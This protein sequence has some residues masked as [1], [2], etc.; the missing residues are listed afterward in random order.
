MPPLLFSLNPS[1]RGALS[2]LKQTR[3]TVSAEITT[4][5]NEFG[6]ELFPDFDSSRVIAATDLPAP[7]PQPQLARRR[8]SNSTD[9]DG[10]VSPIGS[11]GV[12]F[13]PLDL[14][15]GEKFETLADI[16]LFASRP[17]TRPPSRTG[18]RS[19]STSVKDGVSIDRLKGFT[20]AGGDNATPE[21]IEAVPDFEELTKH[22][23]GGMTARQI[24]RITTGNGNP[25]VEPK[26]EQ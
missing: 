1:N 3:E 21:Q 17:P 8:S 18:R 5:V 11:G 12:G 25:D 16:Q 10:I 13:T 2:K 6:P 22:I 7:V 14:P 20:S 26:K 9:D 19:R 24:E 4:V 15:R 23:R